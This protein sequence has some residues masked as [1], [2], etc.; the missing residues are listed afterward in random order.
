M[1]VIEPLSLDDEELRIVQNCAAVL[2]PRLRSAFLADFAQEMKTHPEHGAGLVSRVARAVA[3]RLQAQNAVSGRGSASTS[4][5][6][7][8]SAEALFRRQ[9]SPSVG[10]RPG[11][12]I[13]G[14]PSA[15]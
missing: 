5:S 1:P 8:A 14:S 3:Q 9:P 11:N 6:A 2:P 4:A 10:Y 7:R 12:P 15:R 13:N